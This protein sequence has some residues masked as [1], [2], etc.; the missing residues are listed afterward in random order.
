MKHS[1]G[2]MLFSPGT[3]T[4]VGDDGRMNEAKSEKKPCWRLKVHFPSW[5]TTLNM[6]LELE[7]INARHTFQTT[8]HFLFYLMNYLVKPKE[9]SWNFDSSMVKKN[10]N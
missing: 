4:L 8:Q 6:Q 1:G 7:R 10:K 5:R 3:G 2:S 9:N